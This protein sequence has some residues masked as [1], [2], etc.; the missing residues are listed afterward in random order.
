MSNSLWPHGL[1]HTNLSC[2]SPSP[3]VGSNSCALSW[4]CYPTII[5]SVA[6]FSSN[7][8]P[9]K[10]PAAAE[11]M[12]G[13]IFTVVAL[14]YSD[15]NSCCYA[16]QCRCSSQTAVRELT[17]IQKKNI[18]CDFSCIKYTPSKTNL[19]QE[20]TGR[21]RG[22]ASGDDFYILIWGLVA[23]W[24]SFEVLCFSYVHCSGCIF[25]CS[26]KRLKWST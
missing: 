5:F 25:C 22:R 4:W 18:L 24:F 16:Q 10:C 26:K 14:L 15:E 2:P 17:Q 19:C 12:Q 23:W 13:G 11:W 21:M 8:K 3:G 6:P 9:P 7:W 1:Q 20:L